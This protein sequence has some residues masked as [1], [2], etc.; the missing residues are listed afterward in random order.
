MASSVPNFKSEAYQ[1]HLLC[2]VLMRDGEYEKA[3]RVLNDILRMDERLPGVILYHVFNDLEE[4]CINLGNSKSARAY[5]FE[6]VSQLE[7]MLY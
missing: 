2:K 7:R 6:K 1:Q 5:S 4:C 3:Y